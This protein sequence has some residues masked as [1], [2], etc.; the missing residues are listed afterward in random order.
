MK[1]SRVIIIFIIA[2]VAGYL[3]RMWVKDCPPPFIEDP[4]TSYSKMPLSKAEVLTKNY[5]PD[6]TQ[7]TRAISITADMLGEASLIADQMATAGV[8][9]YYAAPNQ[10]DPNYDMLV[11]VGVDA[12]GKDVFTNM[13]TST[14]RLESSLAQGEETDERDEEEKVQTAVFYT[15]RNSKN[16][17]ETCPKMCDVESP[18]MPEPSDE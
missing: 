8:R 16:D 10:N 4:V 17:I 18:L 13:V 12:N 7:P 5:T 3:V 14:A 1:T 2:F 15:L 6:S 9:I 11:I